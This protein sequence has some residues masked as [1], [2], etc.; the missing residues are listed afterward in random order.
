MQTYKCDIHG[1]C[2]FSQITENIFIGTNLVGKNHFDLLTQLNVTAEI[3]LEF[4][5]QERPVGVEIYLW[6]PTRDFHAPT[7][8]QL[9][10]GAN[11][12]K[13]V[14]SQNKKVYIHCKLG[15]SRSPSLVTAYFILTG[16]SF[17]EAFKLIKD[18]RPE[19]HLENIQE[20]ALTEFAQKIKL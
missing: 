10:T 7:F 13:D 3:N 17:Q 12:I 6:L 15:H 14:V 4:E 9:L 1:S 2:D 8:T 20:E 19:A 16:K 11:V 18:H 5:H